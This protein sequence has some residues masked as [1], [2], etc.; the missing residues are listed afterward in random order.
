VLAVH[1]LPGFV[2]GQ[3]GIHDEAV[4]IKNKRFDHFYFTGDK[5]R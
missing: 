1:L 5:W 2:I 3:L 4:E